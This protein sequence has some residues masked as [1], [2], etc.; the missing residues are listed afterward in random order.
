MTNSTQLARDPEPVEVDVDFHAGQLGDPEREVRVVQVSRD[1]S[2]AR[3]IPSQAHAL[4]GDEETKSARVIFLASLAAGGERTYLLFYGNASASPPSYDT[5]LVV[6]GE[7]YGLTVDNPFY[8]IVLAP[9]MGQ[10]KHIYYKT[11]SEV[12]HEPGSSILGFGPPMDGGH[13]V[14]GTTH[15]GPDWSDEHTGRYRITSWEEPPNY[16]ELR[17]PVCVRLTRSGHPILS[18]G[19][20]IGRSHHVMATVIY[21]FFASTPYFLMESRL[22]VLEEVRFRDCRNDEWVGM[23]PAMPEVAWMERDGTIGSGPRSWKRADPA[24]M[25]YFNRTTRDGFASIHLIGD[26]THPA[27]EDPC[28]VSINPSTMR[29]RTRGAWVRYP[30]RHATMRPGDYVREQNAY[31]LYRYEPPRDQGFGML[32]D[33]HRRLTTPLVAAEAAPAPKPISVDNAMD[34]LR[35]VYDHELYIEGTLWGDRL[36][37]IVDLGLVRGVAIDGNDLTVRLVMPYRGRETWFDWFAGNIEARL[38]ERL[39]GVGRV[40]VPCVREPAWSPDEM[41]RRARRLMA[42]DG[43]G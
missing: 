25:T 17:G 22:D 14:E 9:S 39:E 37:S 41:N 30:L 20:G 4:P 38:R 15:W 10:I 7:G 36:V 13:G 16:A 28:L 31:L 26:C 24:W 6:T 33:H 2:A 42:L 1:G 11:E 18:V 12:G 21:T 8:R 27:W 35:G 29:A 23:I 32:T 5:D 40:E 3:E 34:A 19:P 43:P